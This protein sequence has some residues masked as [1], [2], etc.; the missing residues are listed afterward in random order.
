MNDSIRAISACCFS[1]GPPERELAR[2]LLAAPLVPGA[3][4]E[5]RAARLELEHRG[6]HRLQ[7]PAVVGDEDD[8][9]VEPTSV[10]SSHSSDSMS[11]WFV[12]SSRSRRSGLAASARASDARVSWPPGE[13]LEPAVQVGVGE[14]EAVD[15]DVRLLAPAVAADGLEAR[16]DVGVPRHRLLRLRLEP[17]ELGL[18]L[19]RL[20]APRGRSRAA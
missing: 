2:G 16:V 10:C 6:A 9:R 19:Q 4:E 20:L 5:A 13:R 7:E 17:A 1:I 18:E 12:G 8:R 11:R 14:P 15:G 3:L